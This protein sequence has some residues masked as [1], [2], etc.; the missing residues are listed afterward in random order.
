[1]CK[2]LLHTGGISAPL[3]VK[4]IFSRLYRCSIHFCINMKL[5][6]IEGV[7]SKHNELSYPIV[8]KGSMNALKCIIHTI[9][10]QQ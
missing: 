2:D 3:F 10:R 5:M 8:Y 1:M 4:S 7:S 9:L 6:M